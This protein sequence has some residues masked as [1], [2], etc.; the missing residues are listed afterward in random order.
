M[1]KI[2]PEDFQKDGL[3]IESDRVLIYSK[4]VCPLDC[5]YCFAGDLN[6]NKNNDNVYLSS[7]QLELLKNL[8]ENIKTIM[9]GCDTEFFQ[10]EEEAIRVLRS[11]SALDKDVSVITKL[12]L[13]EK[14]IEELKEIFNILKLKGKLLSFSVSIPCFESKKLWEPNAPSVEERIDT[15]K[16]VSDAGL[17][18]MAAVRPLIPNISKAEIDKIIELT[19]PYVFGYYSGPLY[20]KDSNRGLFTEEYIKNNNLLSTET[21]PEWMPKGNT[22]LKIEKPD[23]M[24]YLKSVVEKYGKAFFDGAAQGIDFIKNN[25][26]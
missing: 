2:K 20:L 1:E 11:V 4:M 8:P 13:N 12:N 24:L 15:L 25:K 16:K 6:S 17:P 22:F 5:K 14:L 9:L 7:K 21:Q 26:S 3:V 19:Y 10:D 18:S 23:L